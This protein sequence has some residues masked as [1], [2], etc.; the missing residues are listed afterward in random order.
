TARDIFAVSLETADPAKFPEEIK[1]VLGIDPDPPQ[2]LA[3]LE[4]KEEFFSSMDNDYQSFKELI[5]SQDGA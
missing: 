3:G 1:K 2:C 5:L 4:D